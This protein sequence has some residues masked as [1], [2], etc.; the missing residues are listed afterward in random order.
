MQGITLL[1]LF[2]PT[3]APRSPLLH[4]KRQASSFP[5]GTPDCA[6]FCLDIKITEQSS[7]APG[8]EQGNLAQACLV[9]NFQR[10]YAHCC[11][12]NCP[13]DDLR[14]A[15]SAGAVICQ[16]ALEATSSSSAAASST[17][18]RASL[19]SRSSLSPTS[20]VNSSTFSAMTTSSTSSATR[21][22]TSSG[23]VTSTFASSLSSALQSMSSEISSISLALDSEL[24]TATT[25]TTTVPE[26]NST[27]TTSSDES[28]SHGSR[29]RLSDEAT[30]VG[31]LVSFGL[32][33]LV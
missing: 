8:T 21:Y 7:L 14:A 12:D 9:Q 16:T 30:F 19:S 1:F 11:R 29:A 28:S 31:L 32:L 2:T 20:S 23:S 5:G 13:E 26:A 3:F 4:L 33:F 15:L 24:G 18:T 6:P 27:T 17:V 22:I 10:A 25:V